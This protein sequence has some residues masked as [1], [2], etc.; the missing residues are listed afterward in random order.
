MSTSGMHRRPFEG[1]HLV[2][3]LF[4]LEKYSPARLIIAYINHLMPKSLT[5][6]SYFRGFLP[7]DLFL[8]VAWQ[9]SEHDISIVEGYTLRYRRENGP[10]SNTVELP[11]SNT[12]YIIAGLG[13]Y[14]RLLSFFFFF[15]CP[16][17]LLQNNL[18]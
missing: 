17:K 12:T 7:S 11:P 10:W 4:C 15:N 5:V 8:Q 2:K 14:L 13:T 1:R 3:T 16:I 9:L 6:L 18:I